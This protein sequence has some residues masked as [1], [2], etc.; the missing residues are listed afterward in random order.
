MAFDQRGP[1]FTGHKLIEMVTNDLPYTL[2][3]VK[4]PILWQHANFT[5]TKSHSDGD[6]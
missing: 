3:S 1:V 2:V 5:G 4:M 6:T